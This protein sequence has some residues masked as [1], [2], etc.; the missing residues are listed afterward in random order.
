VDPWR[1]RTVSVLLKLE[2]VS[3]TDIPVVNAY[4]GGHLLGSV[5]PE[6]ANKVCD[7]TFEPVDA[8]LFMRGKTV[9]ALLLA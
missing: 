7:K 1:G 5:A 6:L 8:L 9:Y 3:W 2:E 4:C